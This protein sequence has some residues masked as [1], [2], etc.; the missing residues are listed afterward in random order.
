M[1]GV[2]GGRIADQVLMLD[3]DPSVSETWHETSGSV[4][5]ES[6]FLGDASHNE[7]IVSLPALVRPRAGVG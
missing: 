2:R 4:S 7:I 5:L 1:N 3:A 6:T